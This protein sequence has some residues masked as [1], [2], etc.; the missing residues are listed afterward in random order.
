MNVITYRYLHLKVV[1]L[2][3]HVESSIYRMIAHV[4]I[5]TIENGTVVHRPQGRKLS[6]EIYQH[7]L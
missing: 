3:Q 7:I 6:Q 5:K 4:N 1:E 2:Q